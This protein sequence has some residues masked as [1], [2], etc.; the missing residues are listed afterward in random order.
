[1]KKATSTTAKTETAAPAEVTAI[2]TEVA[3]PATNEVTAQLALGEAEGVPTE[4]AA[5]AI[6]GER[7]GK[8]RVVANAK[9]KVAEFNVL[10]ENGVQKVDKDGK[11]ITSTWL[12][13]F[14][15]RLIESQ[16]YG[17]LEHYLKVFS[18]VSDFKVLL[19][20]ALKAD[21]QLNGVIGSIFTA[22]GVTV[23]DLQTLTGR[24][25][26]IYLDVAKPGLNKTMVIGTDGVARPETE[27]V[28]V[29][30]LKVTK[31]GTIVFSLYGSYTQDRAAMERA[32]NAAKAAIAYGAE[33]NNGYVSGMALNSRIQAN[34]KKGRAPVAGS[35]TTASANTGAVVATA[36]DLG[37]LAFA[38]QRQQGQ[39]RYSENGY[40]NRGRGN[41]NYRGRGNGSNRRQEGSGFGRSRY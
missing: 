5:A 34:T 23:E 3:T 17:Q 10:D 2:P 13:G 28:P 38:P 11:G 39:G 9:M 32:W 30:W 14:A 36:D 31:G 22:E 20:T 40:N 24:G 8:I 1:M 21:P 6:E 4:V 27:M 25:C 15:L 29:F 18:K 7:T 26:P 12:D 16:K 33:F 35:T 41:G 37:S 19:A